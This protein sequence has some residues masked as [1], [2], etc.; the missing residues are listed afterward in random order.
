MTLTAYVHYYQG[1]A[2]VCMSSQS[3]SLHPGVDP[4]Y[5]NIIAAIYNVAGIELI[6]NFR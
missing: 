2:I 1:Y 5:A 6:F 3:P 4:K